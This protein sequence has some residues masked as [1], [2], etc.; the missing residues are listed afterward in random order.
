[1]SKIEI[2]SEGVFCPK[3]GG[4]MKQFGPK[5]RKQYRCQEDPEHYATD[6]KIKTYRKI[7]LQ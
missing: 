4:S 2:E 3:C 5:S 1:M 7:V 6:N